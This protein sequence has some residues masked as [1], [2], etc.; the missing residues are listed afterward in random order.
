METK[1]RL[2]RLAH[3]NETLSELDPH[4]L[5]DIGMEGFDQLTPGQK[6]HVLL[7]RNPAGLP[8]SK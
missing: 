7:N 3:L 1:T 6:L 4:I 5:K 8:R 2:V